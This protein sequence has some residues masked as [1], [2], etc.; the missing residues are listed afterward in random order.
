MLDE[1]NEADNVLYTELMSYAN[2]DMTNPNVWNSFQQ[3]VDI[4]SMASYYA[5]EIYIGNAD[6]NE[7][8]NY[9]IWR[10]RVAD[11]SSYGDTKWR[12]MLYDTE[13]SSGLYFV[14]E[15]EPDFNTLATALNS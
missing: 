14:H 15:T 1:C 13:F 6:W 5:A 12:W 8:K 2:K 11:E 3:I 4:D 7:T 10:S 9:R